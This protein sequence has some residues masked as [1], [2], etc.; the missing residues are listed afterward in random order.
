MVEAI[1]FLLAAFM[2]IRVINGHF[3]HH[4]VLW[5]M[6]GYISGFLAAWIMLTICICRKSQQ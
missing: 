1:A 3:I 2:C 6:L 4:V 5:K